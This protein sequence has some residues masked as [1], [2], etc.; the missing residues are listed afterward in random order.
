[1]NELK[2]LETETSVIAAEEMSITV[3][4]DETLNLA[5]QFLVKLKSLINQVKET[6]R[7]PKDK[8]WATH[9]SIVAAEKRHLSPLEAGEKRVKAKIAEYTLKRDTA[10]RKRQEDAKLELAEKMEKLG[11]NEMADQVLSSPLVIEKKKTDGVSTKVVFKAKIVNSDLIPDAYYVLD[12]KKINAVVKALGK[13][14]GIPGVEAV[15]E[16]VVSARGL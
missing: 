7:E 3:N 13:S 14:H 11:E 2:T 15:E 5:S 8:A 1:M 4:D 9:K 12:E 6:F 10:E 16:V